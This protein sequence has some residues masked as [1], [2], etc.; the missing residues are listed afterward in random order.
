MRGKKQ[1]GNAVSAAGDPGP[2]EV[3]LP[4]RDKPEGR[5]EC[6]LPARLLHQGRQGT[7]E[8]VARLYEGAATSD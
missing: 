8:A 4:R 5:G 1:E 2:I 6:Y 7:E 3:S